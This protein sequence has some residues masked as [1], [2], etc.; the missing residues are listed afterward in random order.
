MVDFNKI[1]LYPDKFR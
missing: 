1:I